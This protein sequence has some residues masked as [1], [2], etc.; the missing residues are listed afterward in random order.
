MAAILTFPYCVKGDGVTNT[1]FVPH[2]LA[3]LPF[4][5]RRRWG[6]CGGS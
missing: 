5:R 2:R 1:M 6:S 3:V 4:A